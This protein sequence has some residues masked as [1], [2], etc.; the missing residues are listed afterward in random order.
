MN[1]TQVKK[2]LRKQY[3]SIRT[4]LESLEYQQKCDRTCHQLLNHKLVQQSQVILSYISYKKELDLNL[5]HQHHPVTWGIPRCQGKELVWHQWTWG[6]QLTKGSYGILEPD[7]KDITIR[8]ETVDLILVPALAC[9]YQ[10]YRLGYGGG[11]YDRMLAS[12]IW[13]DIPTIAIV[14]D[15]AYIPQLPREK[16]DQP[17]DYVCTEQ[18]LFT[19]E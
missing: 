10:G 17:L 3:L 9:D 1:V 7:A 19:L 18:G 12:D 2:Q 14:F 13:K 6:Q 4:S 5:L 16:W 11:Y 15:F 8:P